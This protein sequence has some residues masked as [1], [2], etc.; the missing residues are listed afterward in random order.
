MKKSIL[1]VASI[2]IVFSFSSCKETTAQ[3]TEE[4]VEEV[5]DINATKEEI[6]EEESMMEVVNDSTAQVENIEAT[7]TEIPES[8]KD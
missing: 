6:L 8:D 4:T 3:T 1:T 5:S 7:P 2:A